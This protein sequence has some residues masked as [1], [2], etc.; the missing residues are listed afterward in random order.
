MREEQMDLSKYP[1]PNKRDY[2]GLMDLAADFFYRGDHAGAAFYAWKAMKG[3]IS[4]LR[5]P[6]SAVAFFGREAVDHEHMA[7]GLSVE[8]GHV[9]SHNHRLLTESGQRKYR[10]LIDRFSDAKAEGIERCTEE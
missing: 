6:D 8:A 7:T 1:D 3:S 10:A 9:F 5:E 2:I 4:T